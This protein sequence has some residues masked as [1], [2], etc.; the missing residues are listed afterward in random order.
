MFTPI[1]EFS[2]S[3]LK[4]SYRDIRSEEEVKE[5][6]HGMEFKEL[7]P[8]SFRKYDE[9][10]HAVIPEMTAKEKAALGIKDPVEEKLA[11]VPAENKAVEENAAEKPAPKKRG[12]KP[13]AVVEAEAAA[14]AAT[15]ENGEPKEEVVKKPRKP[16]AK[17][18]TEPEGQISLDVKPEGE[19][20]TEEEKPKRTYR[21]RTPKT[22]DA[23]T[24]E[25]ETV[26]KTTRKPRAKKEETTND[27]SDNIG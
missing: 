22:E 2:E 23:S 25:G 4:S 27:E 20:P 24:T 10:K 9:I 8:D 26:K 13:K 15:E 6:L 5:S 21:K 3:Q 19:T 12:R 17:K 11:E 16:R 7:P 18:T 1:S 14:K